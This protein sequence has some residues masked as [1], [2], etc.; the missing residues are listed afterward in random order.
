M[1]AYS[2]GI[3]IPGLGNWSPLASVRGSEWMEC[4]CVVGLYSSEPTEGAV[5]FPSP[6]QQ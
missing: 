2:S 6:E 5:V 3:R 4:S 1:N